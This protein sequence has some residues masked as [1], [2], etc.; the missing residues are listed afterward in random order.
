[1]HSLVG[2]LCSTSFH[3]LGVEI[4]IISEILIKPYSNYSYIGI[5]RNFTSGLPFLRLI[6]YP[7][8]FSRKYQQALLNRS[9]VGKFPK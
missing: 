5:P 3:Y 7:S 8:I 4:I 1:M 9:L 2:P 6:L